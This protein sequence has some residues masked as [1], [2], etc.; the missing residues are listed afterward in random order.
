MT[1]TTANGITQINPGY[2]LVLLHVIVSIPI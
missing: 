1:L 2:A